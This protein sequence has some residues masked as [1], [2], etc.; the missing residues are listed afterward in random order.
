MKKFFLLMFCILILTGCGD[1]NL[2]CTKIKKEENYNMRE[3]VKLKYDEEGKKVKSGV[4]HT[5]FDISDEYVDNIDLL[6]ELFKSEFEDL[7]NIGINTKIE[8][9]N[10]QIIVDIEYDVEN[11]NIEQINELLD[12]QLYFEDDLN[13][14][15]RYYIN[16]GYI[17]E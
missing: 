16:N 6:V 1:K 10:E 4:I 2:K 7:T 13:K 5:I 8:E 17:C 12:S 14:V 15:E 11:L 9:K 3:I